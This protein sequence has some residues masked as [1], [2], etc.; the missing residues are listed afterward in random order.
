MM[1]PLVFF[2]LPRK[3]SMAGWESLIEVGKLADHFHP[4]CKF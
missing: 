4:E 1:K 3:A 2:P